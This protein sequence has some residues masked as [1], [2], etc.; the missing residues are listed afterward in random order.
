M[1]PA[2]NTFDGN[3][4]LRDFVNVGLIGIILGKTT[5][6][7]FHRSFWRTLLLSDAPA[8]CA[9][10]LQPLRVFFRHLTCKLET[11]SIFLARRVKSTQIASDSVQLSVKMGYVLT[12]SLVARGLARNGEYASE[13]A[14]PASR[15]DLMEYDCQ[16][17]QVAL[18]H[19]RSCDRIP[20]PP[21]ARPGYSENIHV[22]A[23]AATDVLGAIQ[24]AI[25]M[26][27]NELAANGIPSNMILTPQ[28]VQRT[29]RT[30]TRVTK[31]LWGSNRFVGCA[32]VLCRGFYFTSCMYRNPVNVVGQSIYTIGAVCSTCPTGPH[33][34]NPAI[35]L[36]SY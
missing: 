27:T 35:G 18:N 36:C 22:L 21:I 17:E 2:N 33:N 30:V 10:I 24:N 15:M 11:K 1:W 3:P 16:A 12:I 13:N 26:F 23:T 9:R 29:Q 19:V 20:A 25:V 14:P 5:P 6:S 31:V 34:C 7:R 32:T 28:V 4:A 8:P